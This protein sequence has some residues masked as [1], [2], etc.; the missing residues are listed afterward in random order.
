MNKYCTVA[1]LYDDGAPCFG[2]DVYAHNKVDAKYI[3]DF[4]GI[5]CMEIMEFPPADMLYDPTE[6]IFDPQSN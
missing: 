5:P 3:L 1:F 2:P 4:Q 6:N